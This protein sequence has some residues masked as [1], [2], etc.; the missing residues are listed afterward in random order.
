MALLHLGASR[1]HLGVR[2]VGQRGPGRLQ[3]VQQL[4]GVLPL[5]GAAF[6]AHVAHLDHR[7]DAVGD[8]ARQPVQ[9]TTIMAQLLLSSSEHGWRRHD[10]QPCKWCSLLCSIV[11]LMNAERPSPNIPN[12]IMHGNGHVLHI[13]VMCIPTVIT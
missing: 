13:T 3:L 7:P 4:P 1:A 10:C 11:R 9:G 8:R 6:A 5:A 12:G 2:L